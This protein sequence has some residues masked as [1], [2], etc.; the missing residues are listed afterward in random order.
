[1]GVVRGGGMTTGAG[2]GGGTGSP[3][4]VT[5]RSPLAVR[6]F[7][8]SRSCWRPFRGPGAAGIDLACGGIQHI[9]ADR[10]DP[11]LGAHQK[12]QRAGAGAGGKSRRQ[13][14]RAQQPE[15]ARVG[16]AWHG[17]ALPGG[18]RYDR[19][20]FRFW[21]GKPRLTQPLDATA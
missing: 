12:R 9:A 1:V 11:V 2:G 7:S 18:F 8:A 13:G 21:N 10:L 6:V 15:A 17:D 20:P 4:Q 3:T 5:R 16:V 19:L 14:D